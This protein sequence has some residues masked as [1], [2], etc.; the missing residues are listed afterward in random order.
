MEMYTL[1]SVS[2]LLER[3][4]QAEL[5][6]FPGSRIHTEAIMRGFTVHLISA[7]GYFHPLSIIKIRKIL[8]EGNFDLI[9]SQASKDLWTIVPALKLSGSKIP[10]LLTKQVG[11]FVIKKDY[12]HKWIYNRVSL[13]LAIS[14]VIKNNLLDTCP[15]PEKKIK[16]MHNGI[17]IQRFNPQNTDGKLIR[18]EFGIQDSDLVIGM[19]ARFSPGKGHEEYLQAASELLKIYKHLKFLIVGEPSRGENE[20]AE[21]IKGLAKEYKIE[22]NVIFTGYRSDTP[23]VLSSM[24]IFAFPSHSEAFGIALAEALAMGKPSVCSNSDGVLDIVVDGVTSYL[25]EKQNFMDL[26]E[27]LEFLINSPEKR[28]EFGYA[29]RLR[30]VECFDIEKLSDK[31][32]EI[33]YELLK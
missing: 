21:K 25:F 9:H 8:K 1:Q 19:L 28:K 5:L 33:Y 29:A 22:N 13:V 12:F 30:A 26:A 11:S 3:N 18:K 16:L 27:K 14:N 6:C 23:E 24:D 10:L 15:I 17:D 32:L 2:K 31:M 7:S 4:I 20:Y